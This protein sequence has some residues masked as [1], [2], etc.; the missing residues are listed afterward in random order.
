M[1]YSHIFHAGNFAD[2]FKH[3]ILITLI[4]SMLTKTNGFCYFDTHAGSGYYDFFSEAAQ[5]NKEF[6]QGIGKIFQKKN[7]P[8]IVKLYVNCIQRINNR[9]SQ[10]TISSLRYYPGSPTLMRYFLRS[11]DRMILSE[12][13]PKEFQTLKSQFVNDEHVSVHLLDGYKGLKAFLPPKERR[14][15]ILIDP[16]YER[17]SEFATI[18]ST[19]P[20]AFKRFSTG[21]Y[22]IWYP[23]KDRRTIDQFHAALKEI[24]Q[25]PILVSEIT[26]YPESGPLLLNGCGMVIINPPWQLDKQ[27][28]QFLPWLWKNLSHH[29]QGFSRVFFA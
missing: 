9:L 25:K 19:L 12:L 7:L 3:T 21:I 4:K 17:P 5:K 15:L 11:Q 27:I 10:S 23:I 16:P 2:V 14:G 13:H 18:V 22:A 24:A 8:D 20:S 29:G 1:N 28:D 26:L 6:E